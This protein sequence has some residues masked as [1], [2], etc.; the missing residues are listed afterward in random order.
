MDARTADSDLM[1]AIG[2]LARERES[3][4][5]YTVAKVASAIALAAMLLGT[6]LLLQRETEP[7]T[8]TSPPLIA[9]LLIANL[10]PAI[11]LMVLVA[12][13]VARRDAATKGIGTGKLHTRLVALFSVVAAVPTVVVAIFASILLQ[14]GLE[15][16]FSNRARTMLENTVALASFSYNQ[17]VNRVS[18]ETRTMSGDLAGYLKVVAIEDPR[19]ADA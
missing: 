14:S 6:A 1:P 15:F 3:G 4:R 13:D 11:A 12:R 5:F 10:L 16:W 18:N 2:W 9:L 17:E 7:G 19:F 8:L